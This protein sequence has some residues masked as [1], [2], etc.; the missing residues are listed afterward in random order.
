[1]N[2]AGVTT[3][4]EGFESGGTIRMMAPRPET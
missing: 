2:Y 3:D 1:M 4:Y